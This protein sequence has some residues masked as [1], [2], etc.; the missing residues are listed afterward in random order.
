MQENSS[1]SGIFIGLMLVVIALWLLSAVFIIGYIDNWPDRGT[2][3]DLFGAVNALIP[4]LAFAALI[5]TIVLQ[6][7]EIKQNREEIVLNRKELAKGSK[8]QQKTQQV[9]IQQVN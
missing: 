5:Y 3:G 7:D 9:L 8:L 1:K 6:R 4:G 2:F